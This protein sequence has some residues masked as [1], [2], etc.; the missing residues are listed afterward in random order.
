MKIKSIDYTSIEKPQVV[1]PRGMSKS[2]IFIGLNSIYG[3]QFKPINPKVYLGIN[4]KCTPTID[5][6]R[7]DYLVKSYCEEYEFENYVS[8]YDMDT[9]DPDDITESDDYI[10]DEIDRINLCSCK[11][12]ISIL[13]FSISGMYMSNFEIEKIGNQHLEYE[14]YYDEQ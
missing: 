10:D 14:A 1:F 11:Q 5:L 8:L 4:Q 12:M 6:I 2:Q 3:I 7:S 9:F 13:Q